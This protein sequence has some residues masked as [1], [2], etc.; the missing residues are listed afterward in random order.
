[1]L[2]GLGDAGVCSDAFGRPQLDPHGLTFPVGRGP[3]AGQ[4]SLENWTSPS[5][6]YD[7]PSLVAAGQQQVVSQYNLLMCV[8][9]LL[10]RGFRW[11]SKAFWACA[12][13]CVRYAFVSPVRQRG[14]VL[15]TRS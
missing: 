6:L 11:G 13:T 9:G 8:W 7:F 1:M 15:T 3:E 2:A 10:L 14:F 5:G 4:G 12:C